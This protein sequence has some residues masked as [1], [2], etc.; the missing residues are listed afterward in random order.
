MEI[1]IILCA[2]MVV[3]NIAIYPLC[4]K[5]YRQ[6]D[7][8][9]IAE[10]TLKAKSETDTLPG[11]CWMMSGFILMIS[12]M[13]DGEYAFKAVLVGF[14]DFFLLLFCIIA[15]FKRDSYYTVDGEG[16]ACIKQGYKAWS[17]SWDEIRHARRRIICTGRNFSILYDVVT[18]EGVKRRSLPSI[19]GSDLKKHVEFDNTQTKAEKRLIIILYIIMI[20]LIIYLLL[21]STHTMFF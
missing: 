18:N 21:A 16:L 5:H 9:R 17:H 1:L 19:L 6:E 2:V 12:V 7:A 20:P 15:A 8:E 14:V 10:G 4:K 13:L 11:I 3:L